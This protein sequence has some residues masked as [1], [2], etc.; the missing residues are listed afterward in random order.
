LHSEMIKSF[1][2]NFYYMQ[3]SYNEYQFEVKYNDILTKYKPCWFYFEKK[4]YLTCNS[5]IRY[6]IAKVFTIEI[7]LTQC[8]ESLNKVFKKHVN[9]EILLK[10]LV[11]KIEN[12]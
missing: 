2:K 10:E 6:S 3:N 5:W 9:Q 8:I 12:K 1:I 7:E 4:L 11:K